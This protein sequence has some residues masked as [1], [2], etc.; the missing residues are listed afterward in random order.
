MTYAAPIPLFNLALQHKTLQKEI[1]AAAIRVLESGKFVLGPE[2]V[3]FEEEFSKLMS[4]K[5]CIACASGAS[6]IQIALS[7]CGVGPGMK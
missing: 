6:A 2:T 4:V 1:N 5:H 3:F 7:A